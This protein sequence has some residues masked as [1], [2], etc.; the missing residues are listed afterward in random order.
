M[1]VSEL[2]SATE[3]I[4]GLGLGRGLGM[5]KTLDA[6]KRAPPGDELMDMVVV[7]IELELQALEVLSSTN[8]FGPDL[9]KNDR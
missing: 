6:R 3:V 1:A 7:T 4:V 9:P 5:A 2:K 8:I